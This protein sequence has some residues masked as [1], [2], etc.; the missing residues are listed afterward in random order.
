MKARLRLQKCLSVIL[1]LLFSA[2]V[3]SSQDNSAKKTVDRFLNV[4]LVKKDIKSVQNYFDKK[5]FTNKF[6]FAETCL[7]SPK[8]VKAES[9]KF[10]SDITQNTYKKS[11]KNILNI[12]DFV[13]DFSFV[14]DFK[15]GKLLSTLK[16]DKFFLIK[17]N[18]NDLLKIASN[19]EKDYFY[20]NL[21][22]I[23]SSFPSKEYLF[24]AL[25]V[26]TKPEKN[27][28][29]VPLYLIWLKQNLRWKIIQFGMECQ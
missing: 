10:L 22:Y 14:D 2:F 23:K 1:F 7:G 27:K 17:L 25:L 12:Q 24:L 18:S 29:K 26:E 8:D 11:L 3:C 15:V 6:L 28:I 13:Y 20:Q 16:R 9:I 19:D 5:L 4:W 21:N